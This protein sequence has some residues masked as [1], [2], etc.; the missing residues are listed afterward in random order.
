MTAVGTVGATAV[1]TVTTVDPGTVGGT[2]LTVNN[3]TGFTIGWSYQCG[4]QYGGGDASF[5]GSKSK[6]VFTVVSNTSTA[7]TG[8]QSLIIKAVA[9]TIAG[10]GGFNSS[11]SA[12]DGFG[13]TGNCT[14]GDTIYRVHIK[15]DTAITVGDASKFT[16]NN[17]YQFDSIDS[18]YAAGAGA[19][20]KA[21]SISG[22]ATN[23]ISTQTAQYQVTAT[24]SKTNTLTIQKVCAQGDATCTGTKG[25]ATNLWGAERLYNT[26]IDMGDD[27]STSVAAAG[28]PMTASGATGK[29]VATFTLKAG[30]T[31]PKALKLNNND[32]IMLLYRLG[33]ASKLAEAGQS[34]NMSVD[35]KTPSLGISV[36]PA[37]TT[38]V[39]RSVQAINAQLKSIEAGTLHIAV[40]TGSTQFSGENP[41]GL[42]G[43]QDNYIAQIGQ[44]VLEYGPDGAMME[45]G[46]T[47]F[48]FKG[49]SHDGQVLASK[50]TLTVTGGQFEASTALPGKATLHLVDDS[51]DYDAD[52][53]KYTRDAEG[54]TAVWNLDTSQ[55]QKIADAKDA[56]GN[57][58]I[59]RIRTDGK[60]PVNTV[61][62][63]PTVTL[64]IDYD[65]ATYADVTKQNTFRKITKDGTVCTVY[66]VPPPKK[67]VVG[68]DQLSIRVTNDS[69]IA[70]KLTGKLYGQEGGDP[71]WTGDLTTEEVPVG[72]TARFTSEDLATITGV[73]WD[74][75]AVLE[76][77]TILPKVEVL[78]LIRQY[79]IRMAPL[80]NLSTGAHGVSCAQD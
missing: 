53:T 18:A 9:S 22:V 27:W 69:A 46:V 33:T 30:T 58:A 59:V 64:K 75:R 56:I 16:V 45:D 41:G 60:T 12:G 67:G 43:Y 8:N 63:N 6:T 77:S 76:I 57:G 78:A 72:S 73:T 20:S 19:A 21:Y 74:G 28:V 17:I 3:Y 62:N 80:S 11:G 55:L 42:V 40:S 50:S 49:S 1:G 44:L 66:N 29:N 13:S 15:G 70:G 14:I 2:S 31:T 71:I 32:Q 38:T 48:E 5:T 79:G 37:R 7:T 4:T 26:V 47:P 36:N 24:D 23:F 35:L 25:L 68:A 52:P 51:G 54:W 61:E 65:T 39:A 34:I 10:I